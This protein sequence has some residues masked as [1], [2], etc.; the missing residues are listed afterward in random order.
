MSQQRMAFFFFAV[1]IA[2]VTLLLVEKLILRSGCRIE[3]ENVALFHMQEDTILLSKN[4]GEC[5]V[6]RECRDSVS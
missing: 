1:S 5:R 4:E 3:I 2:D 6:H